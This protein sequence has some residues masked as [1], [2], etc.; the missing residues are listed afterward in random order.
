MYVGIRLVVEVLDFAPPTLTHR[1]KL[2]LAV[3]A[4]NARD[5][6][7]ECMPG[8]EDDERIARRM[9]AS[10][11][12]TRYAVISSLKRKGV[13]EVVAAGRKYRRAVYRIA[14]LA[15]A[16]Q[17]PEIPDLELSPQ[18]PDT[19]DAETGPQG[20]ENRDAE[21][22]GDDFSGSRK[23]GLRVPKSWTQGPE[24]RDPYPSY[25]SSPSLNKDSCAPPEAAHDMGDAQ[26]P[27]FDVAPKRKAAAAKKPT[28]DDDPRFV[29]FWALYPRRRAKPDAFKAWRAAIKD[30]V[31]AARIIAGAKTYA[32]ECRSKDAKFI[33]LPAGWIRDGRY[34]DEPDPD[35]P[36]E[37]RGGY[38]PFEPTTDHSEYESGF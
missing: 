27:L 31:E 13:L 25:S 22:G 26:P 21:R 14:A 5:S 1:E 28:P 7:R 3:L 35:P 18:G 17:G 19:S 9:K 36:A 29:E 20:P 38:Q 37:N 32:D 23:A 15:P 10:G 8:I 4:E 30:G 24:F 16:A 33:K 12:S 6:T 2:A 34:D 11:R